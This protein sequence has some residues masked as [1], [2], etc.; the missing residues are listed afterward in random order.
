MYVSKNILFIQV[1]LL[2]YIWSSYFVIFTIEHFKRLLNPTFK[3]NLRERLFLMPGTGVEWDCLGYEN[4]TN[5]DSGVWN[6]QYLQDQDMKTYSVIHPR[7]H[8]VQKLPG[9]FLRGMKF[10]RLNLRKAS[11]SS[12]KNAVKIYFFKYNSYCF[13][14]YFYCCFN[15]Y[16]LMLY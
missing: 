5:W 2:A 12:C 9:N 14:L 16:C 11:F 15:Y 8:G 13:N 3:T 4:C 1:T 6:P 7:G 10:F